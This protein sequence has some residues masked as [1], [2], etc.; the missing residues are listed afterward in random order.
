M[1]KKCHTELPG[2]YPQYAELIPEQSDAF[3]LNADMHPCYCQYYP[4]VQ[5]GEN[6]KI[7]YCTYEMIFKDAEQVNTYFEFKLPKGVREIAGISGHTSRA[8]SSQDIDQKLVLQ[9]N[10]GRD[11][12][13]VYYLSSKSAGQYMPGL[14]YVLVNIPVGTGNKVQGWAKDLGFIPDVLFP[15]TF[16]IILSC[17]TNRKF[18]DDG[19]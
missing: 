13:G 3:S 8:D 14:S 9:F 16:T 11:L 15:Y 17:I 10:A 6:E 4:H 1:C 5:V 12:G 18:S 19:C 7:I 2:A